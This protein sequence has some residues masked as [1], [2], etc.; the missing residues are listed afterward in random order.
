MNQVPSRG[1]CLPEDINEMEEQKKSCDSTESSDTGQDIHDQSHCTDT[2][3]T[4][5]EK[6][7]KPLLLKKLKKLW[8]K[9]DPDLPWERG[10]YNESNTLLLDDTPYKAL[11][12]PEDPHN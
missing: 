10:V 8:D 11:S 12:N 4:T 5:I 7:H 9:C 3:F 6:R 1:E 2:G